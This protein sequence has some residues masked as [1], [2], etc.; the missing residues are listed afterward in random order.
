[1]RTQLYTKH[2]P[3][4][5]FTVNYK[6]EFES[7]QEEEYLAAFSFE[8]YKIDGLDETGDAHE[9]ESEH[10]ATGHVRIAGDMRLEF[11]G[12]LYLCDPQWLEQLHGCLKEVYGEARK[13]Y[14]N[15]YF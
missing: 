11:N 9:L 14:N 2:Y 5:W 3:E 4:Y 10:T 8:L 1:M 15:E 6:A 13:A 12:E 7:T